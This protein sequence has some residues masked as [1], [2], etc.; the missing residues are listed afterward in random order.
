MVN[1]AS[2]YDNLKRFEEALPL[3]KGAVAHFK[4]VLR[5]DDPK[6]ASTMYLLV[7]VLAQLKMHDKAVL[8]WNQ[9][10]SLE[11]KVLEPSPAI[12]NLK[13]LAMNDLAFSYN[14]LGRLKEALGLFEQL[15]THYKRVDEPEHEIDRVVGII[16]KFRSRLR[17]I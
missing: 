7:S 14:R 4:R 10:L 15:L 5:E 1:V 6:T 9:S 8:I 12:D 13:S 16:A 11:K 2:T 3:L 17:I